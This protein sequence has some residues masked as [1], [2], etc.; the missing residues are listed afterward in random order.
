MLEAYIKTLDGKSFQNFINSKSDNNASISLPKF[1]Y[2]YDVSLVDPLVNLGF[3]EG[4][5]IDKANFSKMATS[6][7][8]NIYIG[9]I[10]HKTFIQ[11]DELGTKAGATTAVD[12]SVASAMQA[13]N[14]VVLDRPF[15][16]AIIENETKL[17][18]F[19]GTVM[20]PSK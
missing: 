5:S 13:T 18:L 8:G 17:P 7:Y 19:I 6:I 3:T 9:D 12:M 16:Y 11:V 14:K 15:V 20:D 10:L 1:K 2:D 4:F